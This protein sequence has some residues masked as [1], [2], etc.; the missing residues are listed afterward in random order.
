MIDRQRDLVTDRLACSSPV[1]LKPKLFIQDPCMRF[2]QVS[3]R[4][5]KGGKQFKGYLPET[6][7]HTAC[8]E[9]FFHTVLLPAQSIYVNY[10]AE[11]YLAMD[12][13]AKS[14]T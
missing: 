4:T 11:R 10:Q 1:R 7:L 13:D 3:F 14:A 9:K 6:A 2:P 12:V 8:V 5:R